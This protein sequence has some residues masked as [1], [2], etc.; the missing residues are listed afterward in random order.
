ML[1]VCARSSL[2]AERL[3]LSPGAV[4]RQAAAIKHS[5]AAGQPSGNRARIASALPRRRDT[6]VEKFS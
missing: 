1:S 2:I 6:A 3:S 5:G 4:P